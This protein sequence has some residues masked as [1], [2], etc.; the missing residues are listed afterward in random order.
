MSALVDYPTFS[1]SPFFFDRRNLHIAQAESALL[2]VS[3]RTLGWQLTAAPLRTERFVLLPK[4]RR[5]LPLWRELP[6]PARST[7]LDAC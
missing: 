7:V 1:D 2:Q 3:F 6:T 4:T 5:E